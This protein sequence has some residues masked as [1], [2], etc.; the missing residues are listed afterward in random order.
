MAAPF[1]SFTPTYHQTSYPGISPTRP[2]L[3]TKGKTVVVTG[4][5]DGIGASISRAFAESG[6]TQIAILGRREQKLRAHAEVIEKEFPGTKVICCAADIASASDIDKA[7]AAVKSTFGTID[8]FVNNA[9]LGATHTAVKDS[10]LDAWWNVIEVNLK[11][12]FLSSRAFLA[13]APAEGAVLINITTGIAHVPPMFPGSSAYAAAK[14]GAL[15]VFEYVA[16]EN[17]RVGVYSVHPGMVDTD[18]NRKGGYPAM[19]DGMF[20]SFFITIFF[21]FL[22]IP[23]SFLLHYPLACRSR[24]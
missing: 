13:Q 5:G 20:A 12:A 15:K 2:E 9:G 10:D 11:G 14:A 22:P 21:L 8:I 1:P 6:S 23:T 18:M 7:F 24:C 16:A 3:S 4:G 19:D 17:P